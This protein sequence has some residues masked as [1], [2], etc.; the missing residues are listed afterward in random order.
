MGIIGHIPARIPWL[1]LRNIKSTR[2]KGY[3]GINDSFIK[4]HRNRKYLFIPL[5]SKVYL[6]KKKIPKNEYDN[7]G[8]KMVYIPFRKIKYGISYD[9]FVFD[10]SKLN[11]KKF[12]FEFDHYYDIK[13]LFR[14]KELIYYKQPVFNYYNEEYESVDVKGKIIQIPTGKPRLVGGKNIRKETK[15]EKIQRLRKERDIAVSSEDYET[16]AKI[17]DEIN[18]LK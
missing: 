4:I 6:K 10:F 7:Q 14:D 15:I 13:S 3:I 12:C 1:T 2:T 8:L 17:R 16:A 11:P 18:K 9:C 5:E